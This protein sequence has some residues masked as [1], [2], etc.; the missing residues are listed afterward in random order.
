[1]TQKD[2]NRHCQSDKFRQQLFAADERGCTQ[3]GVYLRSSAYLKAGRPGHF[4]PGPRFGGKHWRNA[5]KVSWRSGRR[6]SGNVGG[7]GHRL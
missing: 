4:W 5:R 2:R 3:I 1:L 6:R 7:G